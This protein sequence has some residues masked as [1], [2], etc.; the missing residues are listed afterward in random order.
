MPKKHGYRRLFTTVSYDTETGRVSH[1]AEEHEVD[2]ILGGYMADSSAD[3]RLDAYDDELQREQ[4]F[5]PSWRQGQNDKV[6][7]FHLVN[8]NE[9]M[10]F[11][12]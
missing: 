3:R 10:V 1:D 5:V 6:V 9:A 7:T 12:F 8:I 2:R 4:E 11:F